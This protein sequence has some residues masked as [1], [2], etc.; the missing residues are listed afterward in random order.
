MSKLSEAELSRIAKNR[1]K[2]KNLRAA[3]L[4]QHPYGRINSMDRTNQANDGDACSVSGP[5]KR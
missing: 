3:K 5:T 2:A 1:E 4:I